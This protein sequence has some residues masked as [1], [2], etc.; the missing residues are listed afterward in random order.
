MSGNNAL[1]DA[2]LKTQSGR[3]LAANANRESAEVGIRVRTLMNLAHDTFMGDGRP[4]G[5]NM[6][7]DIFFSAK[8]RIRTIAREGGKKYDTAIQALMWAYQDFHAT[9]RL[10]ARPG[11]G[12]YRT[13]VDSIFSPQESAGEQVVEYDGTAEE[14]RAEIAEEAKAYDE[15]GPDIDSSDALDRHD[16][17]VGSDAVVTDLN[18]VD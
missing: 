5:V 12:T 17:V 9:G 14:L 1:K 2:L 15:I 8:E 13:A 4:A 7:P 3:T 16:E 10:N 18:F 6:R 11:R